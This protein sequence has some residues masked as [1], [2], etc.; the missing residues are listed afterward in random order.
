MQIKKEKCTECGT[1]IQSFNIT[2]HLMNHELERK[3]AA[4]QKA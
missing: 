4:K 2:N 1:E 3:A